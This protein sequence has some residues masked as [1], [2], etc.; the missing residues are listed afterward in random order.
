MRALLIAEKPSLMRTIQSVYL[1]HR[2]QFTDEIDFLCQAGHII[3]LKNPKQIDA[4]KYKKWELS[5]LPE[6]FPYQYHATKTE[7]LSKIKQ[8]LDTGSYD[9][10][11]HAG[12]PEQEGELLIRETLLYLHCNLP[13][14][15]F[16]SNDLSTNN[17]LSALL[18]LKDDKNYDGLY[19][20]GLLRQHIDAQMGWNYTETISLKMGDL[21]KTGRVKAAIIS[22]I[23]QKELAI[24][25]YV[26]KITY[27]PSFTYKDCVFINDTEY[28]DENTCLQQLP[29]DDSNSAHIL[30]VT[31]TK[32]TKKA[33]K[34]F[35]Q[36]TLQ[37]EM[38]QLT[39]WQP[40][41][42]L[43]VTQALYE[44]K[45][46]SYPRSG[47]EY[48][49]TSVD[50]GS[51]AKSVI[52]ENLFPV[53]VSILGR[54]PEEVKKDKTYCNDKAIATEGHTG[55]IPTGMGLPN[56]ATPDM[57]ILYEVICRRFLAIFANPKITNTLKV[58]AHPL[59]KSDMLFYYSD[60]I[61]I[62][63]GYEWILNPKYN[64]RT[65]KNVTFE[66][67]TNISPVEYAAK[68]CKSTPPR[69]YNPGSL[70]KTMEHPEDYED[71][72]GKV[73]FELGRESTR[74][75]IIKECL[76]NGYYSLAKDGYHAEQKAMIVYENFQNLSLF[77]IKE[78]GYWESLLD[79][80]RNQ[81]ETRESIEDY[82]IKKMQSD[83]LKAKQLTPSTVLK[84]RTSMEPIGICPHCNGDILYGKYGAFCKNKCGIMIGKAY[85]KDLTKSQLTSILKGKKT[86]IN[87]FISKKG[88]PYNAYLTLKGCSE[89]DFKGETRYGLNYDM[90]LCNNKKTK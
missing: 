13:V 88:T 20:A 86:L 84:N 27:K 66:K 35:K 17:V 10:I 72:N 12:D 19:E 37:V 63:A 76:E 75:T 21:C 52:K 65:G 38:Y 3:G 11:I 29:H 4:E 26:E 31:N 28:E 43:A 6:I 87:G 1:D 42:T 69:R 57:A 90:E 39:K 62:D 55:I 45:A 40:D 53:D 77:N 51:I 78:S 50:I 58:T 54:N 24:Q 44:A 41:K 36:S 81:E 15:R 33:P 30:D 71:E 16:W 89:F 7:L 9:Y 67:N 74:A 2:N 47:C 23:V 82:L 46:V 14:K 85:N 68:E 60:T 64:M 32:H 56:N 61:D 22:L 49:S 34:L 79:K 70:V 59:A 48:I 80:V 83:I 8:A 5:H 18:N 25:N 73:P